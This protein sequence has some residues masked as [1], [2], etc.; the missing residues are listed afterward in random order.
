MYLFNLIFQAFAISF[1]GSVPPGAVN[2]SLVQKGSNGAIKPALWWA[3]LAACLELVHIIPALFIHFQFLR[4]P[5][6]VNLA[7]PLSALVLVILGF[8]TWRKR[9]NEN[10]PKSLT[11][12]AFVFINLFNFA[13]I[14][15]WLGALQWINPEPGFSIWFGGGAALG[16]FVCLGLYARFGALL[17][18]SRILNPLR[19]QQSIAL[20]FWGLGLWQIFPII[21]SI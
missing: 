18:Q 13:A 3:A 16:A 5:E 14:P 10:R 12:N 2:L 11:V 15:F 6:V 9:V 21:F 19:L 8:F 20:S 1:L 7:R 17:S 4:A